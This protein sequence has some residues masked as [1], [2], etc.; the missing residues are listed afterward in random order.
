MGEH[1]GA[2]SDSI[3]NEAVGGARA[4][5]AQVMKPTGK[6]YRGGTSDLGDGD[7]C[8]LTD[9]VRCMCSTA[10]SGVRIRATTW[11]YRDMGDV[12]AGIVVSAVALAL[13]LFGFLIGFVIG[14]ADRG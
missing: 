7:R 2:L 10:S 11:E 14:S 13:V 1:V 4:R 12:L 9:T 5:M 3:D 8:P 6:V